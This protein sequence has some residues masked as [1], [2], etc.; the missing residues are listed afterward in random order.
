MSFN[1]QKEKRKDIENLVP[2]TYYHDNDQVTEC[3]NSW[4]STVTSVDLL[5][6]INQLNYGIHIVK[7]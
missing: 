6:L 1:E 7:N 3:V 5:C 2:K 4:L